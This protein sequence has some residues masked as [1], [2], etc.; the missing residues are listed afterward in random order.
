MRMFCLID[1]QVRIIVIASHQGSYYNRNEM[2]E[3]INSS[4]NEISLRWWL[5]MKMEDMAKYTEISDVLR[6][7]VIPDNDAVR[8]YT[9]DLNYPLR[10]RNPGQTSSPGIFSS[11][12]GRKILEQEFF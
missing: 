8:A 1:D 10:L 12:T 3:A 6:P 5:G 11:K 2:S 7:T 4:G 9:K